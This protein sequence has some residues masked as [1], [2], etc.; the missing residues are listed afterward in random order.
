MKL[1]W[2]IF[3]HDACQAARNVIAVIVTMG[4]AIVPILYTWY[5]IV[6]SWDLYGNI[7]ALK[8]VMIDV[9]KGYKSDLMSTTISVG[10]TVTNTLRTNHDP[11]W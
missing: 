6:A 9:D 4:L 8:I 5:N 7:K 3:V 11:G 2:K 1:I 10:E